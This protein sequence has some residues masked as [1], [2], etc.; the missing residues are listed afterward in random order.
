MARSY[1]QRRVSEWH[2]MMGQ[3]DPTSPVYITDEV[4]IKRARICAEEFA[5]LIVALVGEQLAYALFD[6]MVNKVAGKR[7]GDPGF[8]PEIVKESIDC[9][10]VVAGTLLELGVED[11]PFI[12]EVQDS[13]ESKVGAGRDENG[14]FLKGP[15]YRPPDIIGILRARGYGK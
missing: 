2:A 12:D 14:K 9:Y 4:A 15:N 6:E 3:Q 8:L 13:N 1:L 7:G 10:V 5:E 11:M